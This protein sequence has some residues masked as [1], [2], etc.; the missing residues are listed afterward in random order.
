MRREGASGRHPTVP[1]KRQTAAGRSGERRVRRFSVIRLTAPRLLRWLVAENNWHRLARCRRCGAE[2]LLFGDGSSCKCGMCLEGILE[3]LSRAWWERAS[4]RIRQACKRDPRLLPRVRTDW[5]TAYPPGVQP[6]FRA[7]FDWLKRLWRTGGKRPGRRFDPQTHYLLAHIV[8]RLRSAHV[9]SGT[10]AAIL[11]EADPVKRQQLY[12]A[13]KPE[14]HRFLGGVRQSVADWP[15]TPDA[16]DLWRSVR[17]AH[18]QWMLP[19]ARLTG[20][21]TRGRVR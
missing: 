8:D 4:A 18:R 12:D 9:R 15:R 10:I 16:A 5:E 11:S 3:I 6:S 20:E 19:G 7:P 14:V 17:W 13:L 21:K 2:G 1:R